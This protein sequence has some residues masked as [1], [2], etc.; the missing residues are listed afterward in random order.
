MEDKRKV[1]ERL[2]NGKIFTP[3]GTFLVVQYLTELKNRKV[4][5]GS[6]CNTTAVGSASV[7]PPTQIITVVGDHVVMEYNPLKKLKFYVEE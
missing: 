5:I 3:S 2:V 1:Q 4:F 6:I 7:Y